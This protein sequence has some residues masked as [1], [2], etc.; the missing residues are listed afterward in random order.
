MNL[1]S[2][3]IQTTQRLYKHVIRA[4]LTKSR[5]WYELKEYD[6]IIELLHGVIPLTQ[7]ARELIDAI[8]I[9]KL[10]ANVEF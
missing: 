10:I 8:L 2:D 1:T 5:Q 9:Y 6:R 4:V 7:S 3:P